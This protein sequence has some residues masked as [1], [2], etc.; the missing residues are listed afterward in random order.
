MVQKKVVP[1]VPNYVGHERNCYQKLEK[2]AHKFSLSQVK[3]HVV[4]MSKC[5]RC[6]TGHTPGRINRNGTV[7]VFKGLKVKLKLQMG[8]QDGEGRMTCRKKKHT[9][10]DTPNAINCCH[11]PCR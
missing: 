1:V 11:H 3:P 2:V 5:D 9:R 10:Y 4:P 7:V 8:E 6:V